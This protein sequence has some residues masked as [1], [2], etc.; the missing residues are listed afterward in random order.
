MGGVL[1]PQIPSYNWHATGCRSKKTSWACRKGNATSEKTDKEE[2]DEINHK[3][4]YVENS[5]Q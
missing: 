3:F 5:D 4:I 2:A 1:T